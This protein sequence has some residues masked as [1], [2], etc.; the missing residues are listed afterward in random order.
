M[1]SFKPLSVL[2][3]TSLFLATSVRVSAQNIQNHS[4]DVPLVVTRFVPSSGAVELVQD[5]SAKDLTVKVGGLSSTVKDAAID[6]GGKRV[7]LIL[8]ASKRI[9]QD[10]WK[11]ETEMAVSLIEHARPEDKFSL[12][13]VGGDLPGGSLLPSSAVQER[14]KKLAVS[15]PDAPDGTERIYDAL[16]LMAKHLDPPEFGDTIFLFGHPEDSGSNASPKQVQEIILRNRLRF[17]AVSFTD[18]RGKVPPGFDLNK[19]MPANAGIERIDQIS[20]ATGYFVSFHSPQALNFP[21]QIPLFK[22]FLGDLYAGIAEPY[23]LKI[24]LSTSGKTSLNLVI[25]RGNARN[26]RQVDV[27]YPHFIYRCSTD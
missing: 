5:L 13:I 1:R 11:L 16:L 2:W 4:C 20:H 3:M 19:P 15:R 12:S 8:D 9:P 23:R 27:H 7:G 14:L 22:G 24:D 18:M 17:Y 25:K 21:G 26:I 10:E 6:R